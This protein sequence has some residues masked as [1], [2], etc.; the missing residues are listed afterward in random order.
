[1]KNGRADSWSVFAPSVQEGA[2]D[3]LTGGAG[4]EAAD[5]ECDTLRPDWHI[6]AL[7]GHNR[8]VVVVARS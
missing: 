7:S 8:P 1:M 4:L 6:E 5:P 3:T 2:M